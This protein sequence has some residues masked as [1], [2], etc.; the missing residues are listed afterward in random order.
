MPYGITLRHNID[1]H[2]LKR[3]MKLLKVIATFAVVVLLA[4]CNNDKT[5]RTDAVY[6]SVRDLNE[7]QLASTT[8]TKT[9]AVRDPY[10]TD[11][12]STP[13]R[14]SVAEILRRSVNIIEH[15]IKIG[16]RVG[17]YAIRCEYAA[18]INLNRL[19]P[20]DI[21][22]TDKDG[23]KRI[24]IALPPVEIRRL[25]NKFETEVYHERS[26][27]MRSKITEDERSAMRFKASKKLE[28]DM[29]TAGNVYLEELKN[30]A[31]NKAIDFFCTFLI[32]LGYTPEI[33][34][35]Q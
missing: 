15:N 26:S 7:L 20:D 13:D 29:K 14:M 30:Q 2:I 24:A 23:V 1:Q 33:T 21:T 6:Q 4:A 22:I 12:Q 5:N 16:E 10:Y 11:R 8:V 35:K 28:A 34:F 3:T 18:V 32:N 9:Y 31:Q 27:G 19:S 25:G 17:V